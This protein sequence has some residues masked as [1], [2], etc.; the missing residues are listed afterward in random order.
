[1]RP[2]KVS[3]FNR[4]KVFHVKR[5]GTIGCLSLVPPDSRLCLCVGL[6]KSPAAKPGC[7]REAVLITNGGANDASGANGTG[8]AN[9]ASTLFRSLGPSRLC[10]QRL[11]PRPALR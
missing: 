8:G 10:R 1:M 9:G 2:Y 6:K 7:Y 4:T 11:G 5:F 3:G